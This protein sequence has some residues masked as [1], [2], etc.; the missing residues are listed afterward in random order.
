LI[1]VQ[2]GCE[3][4]SKVVYSLNHDITASF[5]LDSDPETPQLGGGMVGLKQEY[6]Y[7]G[8]GGNNILPHHGFCTVGIVQE[9]C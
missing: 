8:L 4:K 7:L 1:Y 5:I 3:K 6:P 9:F 2:Y